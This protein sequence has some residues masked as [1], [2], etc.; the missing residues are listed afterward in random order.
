MIFHKLKFHLMSLNLYLKTL[1][2]ILIQDLEINK[3]NF[4]NQC[5]KELLFWFLI[6][7]WKK[8]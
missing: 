6:L 4:L 8:Y 1:F 3:F 5:L 2:N 7:Q